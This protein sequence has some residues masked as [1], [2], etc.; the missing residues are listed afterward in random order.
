MSQ[1]IFIDGRRPKSK[2]EVR[3]AVASN[4]SSVRLERTAWIGDEY[5]GAVLNAP[6][7]VHHFVGPDPYLSRKFYGTVVVKNGT[8]KVK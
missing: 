4:P 1:G 3:E 2:K 6:E 8:V 7:G 5:D